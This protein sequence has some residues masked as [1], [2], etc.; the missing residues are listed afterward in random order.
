[1]PAKRGSVLAGGVNGV[2]HP[3]LLSGDTCCH[4][5]CLTTQ[6]RSGSQPS[7]YVLALCIYLAYIQSFTA[8]KKHIPQDASIQMVVSVEP[9]W[10]AGNKGALF[11][12]LMSHPLIDTMSDPM[13]E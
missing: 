8:C 2:N 5:K 12:Y 7:R 9:V 10:P 13:L 11:V 4:C 3:A 1:M 6:A